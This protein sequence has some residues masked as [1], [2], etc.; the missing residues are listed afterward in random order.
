MISDSEFPLCGR[1][2]TSVHFRALVFRFTGD[3]LEFGEGLPSAL[4]WVGGRVAVPFSVASRHTGIH[5]HSLSCLGCSPRAPW[6]TAGPPLPSH[7]AIPG[8]WAFLSHLPTAVGCTSHILLCE[9]PPHTPGHSTEGSSAP[10]LEPWKLPLS[11]LWERIPTLVIGLE[12]LSF[13]KPASGL[14]LEGGQGGPGCGEECS[15]GALT[16]NHSAASQALHLPAQPE[17]SWLRGWGLTDCMW[18][19][20]F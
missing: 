10:M 19:R 7:T 1:K 11:S 9:D 12:V 5:L 15:L 2:L 18:L 17:A 16:G 14:S 4:T 3:C 6:V 20:V 13:P 8:S